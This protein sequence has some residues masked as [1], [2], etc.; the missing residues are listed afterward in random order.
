[1]NNNPASPPRLRAGGDA[2]IPFPYE[3]NDQY[4]SHSCIVTIYTATFTCI[5]KHLA[6]FHV[7]M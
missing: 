3:A 6:G 5:E 1:M 7:T 2:P 4:F